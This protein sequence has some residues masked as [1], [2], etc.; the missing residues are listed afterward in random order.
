ME[1]HKG[2]GRQSKIQDTQHAVVT[3]TVCV[4]GCM[5]VHTLTCAH[6]CVNVCVCACVSIYM[7][8]CVCVSIY[9]CVCA[10]VCVQQTKAN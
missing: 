8:V 7:C 2:C 10:C 6:V 9:V 3:E 1:L 5:R 4:R